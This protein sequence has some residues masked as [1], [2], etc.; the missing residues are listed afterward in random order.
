MEPFNGSCQMPEQKP[1]R[2]VITVGLKRS[3]HDLSSAADCEEANNT[4]NNSLP[5]QG[6][7]LLPL[8]L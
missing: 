8:I 2:G 4:D 3:R 6:I 1:G 7:E 5:A